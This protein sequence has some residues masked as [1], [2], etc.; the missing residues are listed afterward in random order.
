VYQLGTVMA[1]LYIIDGDGGVTLV[2]TLN[3]GREGAIAQNLKEVGRTLDDVRAILLTH[4]HMDH[5]GSA[6]AI[7]SASQARVYASEA[8]TPAI[9]GIVKPPNPST[10]WRAGRVIGVRF[11]IDPEAERDR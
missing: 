7:K 11:G 2:D 10:H 5:T 9:Q 6:A 8:D 1:N 4:S 3:R